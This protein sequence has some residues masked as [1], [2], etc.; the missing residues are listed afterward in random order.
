[1]V[2]IKYKNKREYLDF[3]AAAMDRRFRKLVKSWQAD[4][5]IPIPVHPSRKRSRGYNQAEEL[6]VRLSKY[7]DI[8][9]D[10]D[11]LV[12]SKKT[13]PQRKLNPE[14]RLKNLQEA[15]ALSETYGASQLP[16][17]VILIDDIYTTGS[18]IEACARRLK[19]AGVKK[20]HFLSICIGGG[21]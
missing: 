14:E 19:A 6:A 5:L 2:A 13:A 16:E 20:I 8:P 21:R 4:V 17:C 3:Y 15:F 11:L 10:C 18:T 7:W 9:V 12:R 1:M